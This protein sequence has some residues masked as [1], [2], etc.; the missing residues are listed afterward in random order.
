MK[1]DIETLKNVTEKSCHTKH[2]EWWWLVLETFYGIGIQ[3]KVKFKSI[4]I[5]SLCIE[6]LQAVFRMADHIMDRSE[7][8]RGR[9]YWYKKCGLIAI[10]DRF[11]LQ[12]AR[13]VFQALRLCFGCFSCIYQF[14]LKCMLW[15]CRMSICRKTLKMFQWSLVN[16]FKFRT[17][18]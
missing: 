7:L 12:I 4:Y 5:L 10:N 13:W 11:L 14:V 15:N 2:I 17:I 1:M 6:I 16:T 9:S 3:Q 18:I 8:G